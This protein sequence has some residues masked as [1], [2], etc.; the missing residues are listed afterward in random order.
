MRTLLAALAFALAVPAAATPAAACGGYGAE[1]APLHSVEGQ[2]ATIS[3]GDDGTIV[4]FVSYPVIDG[5]FAGLYGGSYQ[6]RDSATARTLL[7]DW[8]RAQ[9]KRVWLRGG[10]RLVRR[11]DTGAWTMVLRTAPDPAA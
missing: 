3:R 8:N 7:R 5:E 4:V 10:V 9:R 11:G 2:V 6:V 1:L